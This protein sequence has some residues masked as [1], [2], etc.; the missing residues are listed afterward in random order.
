MLPSAEAALKSIF[1]WYLQNRT[2]GSAGAVLAQLDEHLAG[3]G[4]AW[5]TELRRRTCR[6]R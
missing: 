5:A 4:T 2:L 3:G 6:T 1:L